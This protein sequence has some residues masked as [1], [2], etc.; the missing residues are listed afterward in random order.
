MEIRKA[1]P[2]DKNK[3]IKLWEYCFNDSKDFIEHYFTNIYSPENTLTYIENNNITT[4]LQLNPCIFEFLDKTVLT[5]YIVGIS[6]FPESRGSGAVNKLF[7][8]LFK[9]LYNKGMPFAVLMAVDYG[10]YRPYSFSNIQD[11]YII[12]GKTKLLRQKTEK[13]LKFNMI[14]RESLE[15][16]SVKLSN[17]F[18]KNVPQKYSIY[19]SRGPEKFKNNLLEL[20]SDNGFACYTTLNGDITGYFLYYFEKTK[21]VVKELYYNESTTLKEILQFIYNHNTQQEDFEIRDDFYNITNQFIQN[22]REVD[23]K[24]MPFLMSRVINLKEFLL[25]SNIHKK[26]PMEIRV[27]FSDQHIKENNQICIIRPGDI[28]YAEKKENTEYDLSIDIALLPPLFFGAL[29]F[30][31]AWS[32]SDMYQAVDIEKAKLF[33]KI[34]SN[35][36]KIFFNEYV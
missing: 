26:I 29:S 19:I 4:T 5:N 11:K 13:K 36:E 6:S 27:F 20:F 35:K 23:T 15:T 24:I 21:F 25:L 16:D 34:F 22:P 9:D 1:L 10:L 28:S 14:T 33:I 2:E 30:E 7:Q 31:E 8:W 32:F 12:S 18:K 3:I 17:Y